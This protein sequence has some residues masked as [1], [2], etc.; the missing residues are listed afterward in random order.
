LSIVDEKSILPIQISWLIIFS[1]SMLVTPF[2]LMLRENNVLPK[3]LGTSKV[4]EMLIGQLLNDSPLDSILYQALIE[5]NRS[6]ALMFTLSDRKV[7]IGKVISM[8][9]PNEI[10]GPDQEVAI[11]PIMSGY[12]DKDTLEVK[13]VTYYDDEKDK[14]LTIIIRQDLISSVSEFQFDTY[15][16]LNPSQKEWKPI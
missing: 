3:R 7:Y 1:S 8:G 10:E 5:K 11:V 13:F 16:R 6:T 15:K 4:K 2:L 9:E 14:D 12:R